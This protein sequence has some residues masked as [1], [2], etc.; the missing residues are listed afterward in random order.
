LFVAEQIRGDIM[1]K[2]W[3][4]NIAERKKMAKEVKDDCEETFDSLD[5]G[6]LRI[7]RDDFPGLLGQINIVRHL[8]K[9]KKEFE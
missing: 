7:G 3:E 5:K 1:L 4:A 2:V 9:L 8:L 6:S